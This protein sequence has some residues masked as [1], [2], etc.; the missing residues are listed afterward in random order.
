ME[1]LKKKKAG[2]ILTG[3][4]ALV[5]GK[6]E[7]AEYVPGMPCAGA[8]FSLDLLHLSRV[9]TWISLK[10]QCDLLGYSLASCRLGPVA[11]LAGAH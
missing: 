11:L 5:Q 4:S 6:T 1:D 3:L 7:N 8:H 10:P 2:I 9:C